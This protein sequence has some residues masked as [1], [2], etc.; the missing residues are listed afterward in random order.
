MSKV[1]AMAI[2]TLPP[3][4]RIRLSTP[5]PT[6]ISCTGSWR[7]ARLVSGTKIMPRPNPRMI[8][9]QYS[10]SGLLCR[11]NWVCRYMA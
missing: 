6:E 3:S 2:P 10:V 1:A 5:E 7:M 8:S 4:W 9:G 11:V